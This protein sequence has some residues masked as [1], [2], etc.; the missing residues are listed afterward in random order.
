AARMAVADIRSNRGDLL[1]KGDISTAGLLKPVLDRQHGLRK[2]D[3]LSH[4]AVMEHKALPR[5][6]FI[7]DGG[8]N[9]SIN[10]EQRRAI[11]HNAIDFAQKV[12]LRKP[13]I[14]MT[15]L[16]EQ[17]NEKIPETGESKIIAE[18]LT[19]N[20]FLADGPIAPDVLFSP[21]AAHKK[22]VSD[23]ISGKADIFV[24]PNI[25]V[26]NFMIKILIELDNAEV[27]GIILGA[28]VPIILL[29]RSDV[30][31]TKLNSIILGLL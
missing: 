30:A 14:G 5:L 8:I 12:L 11:T 16:I 7:T 13:V 20:G 19:A 26:A 31:K 1:M 24:A 25:S 22:G 21:V 29:S 28:K 10:L 2:G 17:V 6:L 4:I 23:H 18:E 9:I 3:I 27:G 15:A